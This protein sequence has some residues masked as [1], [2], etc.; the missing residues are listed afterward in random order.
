MMVT[1]EFQILKPSEYEL[2]FVSLVLSEGI[3]MLKTIY[4]PFYLFLLNLCA[5]IAFQVFQN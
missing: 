2:R 5:L 4:R 3:F 1:Q